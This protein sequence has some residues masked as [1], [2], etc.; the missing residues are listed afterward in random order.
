MEGEPI[1]ATLARF[2][3]RLKT[4]FSAVE[5]IEKKLTTVDTL[6]EEMVTVKRDRWW[7]FML[8]GIAI[9]LFE[10][11]VQARGR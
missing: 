3:E 1:E 11:Y 5:R 8:G 9:G 7:F 4:I 6:K 2:E 10:A